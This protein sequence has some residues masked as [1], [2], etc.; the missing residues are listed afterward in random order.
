MRSRIRQFL[1]LLKSRVISRDLQDIYQFNQAT[2]R[3]LL[4]VPLDSESFGESEEVLGKVKNLDS[5]RSELTYKI[6]DSLEVLKLIEHIHPMDEQG[7]LFARNRLGAGD[8][9]VIGYDGD[10]PVFY[11]WLMF[12]EIEMTYGVFMPVPTG[13]AF[14][15][16]LFTKSSHRRQGAMTGFY[17]YVHNYLKQNNYHT[18]YIGISTKNRPSIKA[19]LK[20][21]FEKI[22]YFY[23]LKLFG[24]SLTVANFAHAKRF[25]IN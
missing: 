3:D 20:T 2:R 6:H 25:H 22:G 14:G 10:L 7:R 11:G 19:H 18:I 5:D 13:I 9:A 21:G 4:A 8:K 1:S 17:E 15:Y 16:N 24:T 12:E 23:T